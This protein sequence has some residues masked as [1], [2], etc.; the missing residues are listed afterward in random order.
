MRMRLV[1]LERNPAEGK[2]GTGRPGD[3]FAERVELSWGKA[4]SSLGECTALIAKD[5]AQLSH[6]ETQTILPS[7]HKSWKG[8]LPGCAANSRW[9]SG[10]HDEEPLG[11]HQTFPPGR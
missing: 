4:P 5:S 10:S 8:L 1:L 3:L 9:Y 7:L 11:P 2:E 6:W